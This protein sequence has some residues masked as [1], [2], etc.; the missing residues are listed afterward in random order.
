MAS[1]LQTN[2]FDPG[3]IPKC[4]EGSTVLCHFWNGKL[5]FRFC[6]RKLEKVTELLVTKAYVFP[7]VSTD[8]LNQQ[9]TGKS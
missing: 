2:R 6:G 9:F 3:K 5:R 1:Y 4:K 8:S 7:D